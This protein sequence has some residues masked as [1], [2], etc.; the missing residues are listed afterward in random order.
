MDPELLSLIATRTMPY[1][2]YKGMVIADLPLAY[3]VWF[4]RKGFPSGEIGRLLALTLEI[5]HNGLADLLRPL[6]KH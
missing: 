4:A 3:L 6:R 5:K 1:G 2:K